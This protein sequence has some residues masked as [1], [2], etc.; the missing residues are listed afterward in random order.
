MGK[1]GKAKAKKAKKAQALLEPEVRAGMEEDAQGQTQ[2][3]RR[4]RGETRDACGCAHDHDHAHA[5]A[6]GYGGEC[7]CGAA[8]DCC[9]DGDGHDGVDGTGNADDGADP[10]MWDVLDALPALDGMVRLCDDGWSLGWHERDRGSASCLLRDDEVR[11]VLPLL[12]EP[13]AWRPAGVAQPALA[14]SYLLVTGAGA[15]LH[16]VSSDLARCVGII[17]L[18]DAGDAYRV[19]WGLSGDGRASKELPVLLACHAARG[20]RVVYHAHTPALIAL[21]TVL[22][23]EDRVF[24]RIL[25]KSLGGCVAAIPEGVGVLA[26]GLLSDGGAALAAADKMRTC[27]AVVLAQQG[28]VCAGTSFDDAFGRAHVLEKAAGVYCQARVLNGGSDV[29][30]QVIADDDLRASC[31]A[32]GIEL[33]EE[34][35]G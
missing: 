16:N 30:C 7:S 26:W 35:L 17:E 6:H 4:E 32:A 18:N 33:N 29:F 10:T 5:H 2:G 34:F 27:C 8:D 9:C 11:P 25:W 13:G 22:P 31:R 21:T 24:T 20:A 1:K 3:S 14:G 23:L 15:Y 28:V 19:V 12:G